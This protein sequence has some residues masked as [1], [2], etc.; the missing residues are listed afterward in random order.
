MRRENVKGLISHLVE[1]FYDQ[2]FASIDY[3]DT[4]KQLKLKYDQLQERATSAA[5]GTSTSATHN[6]RELLM[7]NRR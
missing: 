5:A 7:A 2:T 3:V 1:Q 4:F 6:A